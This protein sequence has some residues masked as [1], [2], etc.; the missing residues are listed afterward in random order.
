MHLLRPVPTSPVVYYMTFSYSQ[1]ASSAVS[2]RAA[3]SESHRHEGQSRC[4]FSGSVAILASK[5]KA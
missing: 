5:P 4:W 1:L 2:R 3:D